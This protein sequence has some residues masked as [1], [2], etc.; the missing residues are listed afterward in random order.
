MTCNMSVLTGISCD[1]FASV[2][3]DVDMKAMCFWLCSIDV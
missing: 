1:L 3:D 2:S